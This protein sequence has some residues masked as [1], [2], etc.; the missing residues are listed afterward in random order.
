[1]LK[2]ERENRKA[3][4]ITN[5]WIGL[6]ERVFQTQNFYIYGIT[7]ALSLTTEMEAHHEAGVAFN[8][9]ASCLVAL[10]KWRLAN[11]S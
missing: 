6:I 2:K 10:P 11:F 5:F 9:G 4:H 8:C 1:M 3:N 7:L